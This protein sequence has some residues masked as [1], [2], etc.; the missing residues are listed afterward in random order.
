MDQAKDELRRAL[1]ILDA[2]SA[3]VP[4]LVFANKQDVRSAMT[5]EELV[6][7]L[8]LHQLR[9][10]WFL[11]PCCAVLGEGLWEGFA[12]LADAVRRAPPAKDREVGAAK[13]AVPQ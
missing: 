2:V 13:Q 5:E 12:W 9:R 8:G 1:E 6:H 7:S 11:Q 4:L 10:A 3:N